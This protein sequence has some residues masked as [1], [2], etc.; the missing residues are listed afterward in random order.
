MAL[1]WFVH[2]HGSNYLFSVVNYATLHQAFLIIC[3]YYI[4]ELRWG[5]WFMK[6]IEVI[7]DWVKKLSEN[8]PLLFFRL[9][10]HFPELLWRFWWTKY[11]R[12]CRKKVN[13]YNLND[14]KVMLCLICLKLQIPL[15]S[16][17][18]NKKDRTP[19]EIWF[20]LFWKSKNKS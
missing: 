1:K 14:Y 4:F 6:V 16:F 3:N 8:A 18:E 9:L 7:L 10:N 11:S 2:T 17:V 12:Y 15:E 13:W 5:F 19:S 20:E